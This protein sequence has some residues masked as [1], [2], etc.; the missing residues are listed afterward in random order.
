MTLTQNQS[1]RLLDLVP[2]LAH[3]VCGYETRRRMI[4]YTLKCSEGHQTQSW[5]KSAAAYD[6]LAKSG[7][8][9]CP[10]CGT[11]DVEKAVMA[12]RVA[13]KDEG[14]PAISPTPED[15]ERHIAQMREKV[16]ST[17]DYVG[18]RF[19]EEA[20]AM[21]LGDMPERPIYG[22]ARLD[23]AKELLSDGVPVMPLPFKPKRKLS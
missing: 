15:V 4:Q 13:S 18:T 5:F 14:R 16:E 2:S 22:E 23:Q 3:L 6:A 19:A 17:S 21:H 20:R 7:H 11:S 12:P 10:V 8:L 9:S 1:A